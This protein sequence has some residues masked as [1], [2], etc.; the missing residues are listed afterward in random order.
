VVPSLVEGVPVVAFAVPFLTSQGWRVLSASYAVSDTPLYAFL[1]NAA[2]I[3]PYQAY[4]VDA[5]GLVV[6]AGGDVAGSGRLLRDRDPDVAR[7]VAGGSQNALLGEGDRQRYL[8]VIRI[9]NAPWR[10]VMVTETRALY[11]QLETSWWR[12]PW[13]ALAGFAL[14]CLVAIALFERNLVQRTRWRSVL[15]TAGDAFIGIDSKGRVTGWNA[16]ATVTFGWTPREVMGEDLVDVLVPEP[17]RASY[18]AELSELYATGRHRLPDG[19]MQVTALTRHGRELPVELSVSAM[20]W[21]GGYHVNAFVRDITD[22]VRAADELTQAERRFRVAFDSAPEP[23]A[24]TGLDADVG[25]LSRVNAALCDLLGY[26][27]EQLEERTLSDVAHPDDRGST[28]ELVTQMA[29]GRLSAT[30]AEVRFLHADGHAVWVELSTNVIKDADD[31]PMY[32]VT[33]ID[34][35]TD[36][37]AE[38]ERLNALALQDTLTGLAN[39]LLLTDRLTQAVIRTSRSFRTLAVLLCDLDGFKPVNDAHGHA[40]GDAVLKEVAIRIRGAVRPADTVARLGGDEFVILCEDLEDTHSPELIAQRIN[41][42]LQEPFHVGAA[43]VRIGISV[44]M[45][46]GEGPGLSADAML[47]EADADMYQRKRA[48]RAGAEAA[49]GG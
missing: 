28:D 33:Q 38:T 8:T 40:A 24:L 27:A 43:E 21:R 36:R 30:T 1:N 42:A 46:M 23:M 16:A 32:A 15:D 47:A 31:R 9:E 17:H 35:V 26:S 11:D 48:P 39:R 19:P 4:V 49:T 45:A 18:R 41:E 12:S 2:T 37:R 34:D 14:V 20:R 29:S 44:G 25:R 3:H 10:L 6:S 13:P 22:R 7:A 5:E